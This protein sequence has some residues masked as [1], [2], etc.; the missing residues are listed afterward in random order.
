[1]LRRQ[2]LVWTVVCGWGCRYQVSAAF[3]NYREH[4]LPKVAYGTRFSLPVGGNLEDHSAAGAEA[5]DSSLI[6]CTV[7][8]A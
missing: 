2:D 3:V 5:S 7:E 6:G 1:V 8:S 4:F